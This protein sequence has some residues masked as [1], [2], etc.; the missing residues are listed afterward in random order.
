M[1][2]DEFIQSVSGAEP[3]AHV[4]EPLKAL[5]WDKKGDWDRAHRI[6][7]EIPTKIGSWVHAYLHREEGDLWNARYWYG[8]AGQAESQAGL[9]EEW[10]DISENLLSA[11]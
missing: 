6:A 8:R 5:W 4:S 3:P 2:L 10:E 1:T 11:E 9:D 7:Q